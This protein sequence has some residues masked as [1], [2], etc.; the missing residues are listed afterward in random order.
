MVLFY[1]SFSYM[2]TY[3]WQNFLKDST[4]TI[5]I[6]Q[7]V[8]QLSDKFDLQQGIEIGPGKGS[9]T[10]KLIQ[11]LNRPL[12]L[13]EKDETL[14]QQL[15]QNIQL[16]QEKLP[17]DQKQ[18]LIIKMSDAL[19]VDVAWELEKIWQSEQ[20]T[21]VVGNLPYYITSP[22]LTKFF[23]WWD[24]KFPVWV[25]M[26]QKEVADKIKTDADK[27]SYLWRLLNFQYEVTYLKTVPAK[28][29]TP[30]PKVQSAVFS[31]VSREL[32]GKPAAGFSYQKMIDLLDKISL[33]KRKTLWKCWKMADLHWTY[34]LPEDLASKRLEEIWLEEM[35]RILE[36]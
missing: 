36:G 18:N 7:K 21:I 35:W 12:L 5:F 28:A 26:V 29:F 20:K 6:A 24:A 33:Y 1:C 2:S 22:L 34:A 32:I 16:A 14:L 27:K 3:L 23:W 4:Y 25:F 11:Y 19:Q 8:A 15:Q 13:L 31:L 9:L 10:K 17:E 30:A